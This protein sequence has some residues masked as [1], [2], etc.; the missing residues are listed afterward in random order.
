MYANM[1]REN[2]IVSKPSWFCFLLT[3]MD[4]THP[5]MQNSVAKSVYSESLG[6]CCSL[7][8]SLAAVSRFLVLEKDKPNGLLSVTVSSR[9]L[10]PLSVTLLISHGQFSLCLTHIY[11]DTGFH[12]MN[13]QGSIVLA[14]LKFFALGKRVEAES[15]V[16]WK[17]ATFWT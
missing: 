15:D 4:L 5:L 13:K 8:L 17:L 14:F 10:L 2:M 16:N 7:S 3:G 11:L 9:T 1:Q 12:P 6:K